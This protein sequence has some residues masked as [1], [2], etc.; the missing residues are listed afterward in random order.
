MDVHTALKF[1]SLK[2]KKNK[3]FSYK[4]DAEILISN[5]FKKKKRGNNFEFRL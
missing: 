5:V 1:A 2:L 3:I 4:L